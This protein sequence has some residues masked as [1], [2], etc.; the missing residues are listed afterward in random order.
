MTSHECPIRIFTYIV[1]LSSMIF[2]YFLLAFRN[3]IK[4]R[5]FA[6]VNTLGLAV[7]LASAL[8]IMLY[9]KDELT[10]DTMHPFANNTYRMGYSINFPNGEK[11]AAPY[12]PAGW[13]NYLK[14][15]YDGV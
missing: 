9:V 13:D 8:F 10:Y 12:A 1:N 7:G 14:E 15:N 4:Q 5:G 3:I 11:E 6:I 2:N